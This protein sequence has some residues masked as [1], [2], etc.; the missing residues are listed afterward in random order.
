MRFH[1]LRT[2]T[3][4]C[5]LGLNRY[6]RRSRRSKWL[7]LL[8]GLSANTDQLSLVSSQVRVQSAVYLKR[9]GGQSQYSALLPAQAE[10]D[11]E[12]FSELERWIVE[13]RLNGEVRKGS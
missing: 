4:L 8:L 1:Y 9:A 3:S 10:S 12:S 5:F 7:V 6:P 13:R 11:S 2:K